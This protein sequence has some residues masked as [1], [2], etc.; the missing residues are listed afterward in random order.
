MADGASGHHALSAD[1]VNGARGRSFQASGGRGTFSATSTASATTQ[2]RLWFVAR[3]TKRDVNAIQDR[4]ARLPHRPTPFRGRRLAH[5]RRTI[6]W[7]A[8][9]R[10]T[11]G[12]R[13]SARS[14]RRAASHRRRHA[15][16][17]GR[18]AGASD[19]HPQPA[20][21]GLFGVAKHRIR[22]AMRRN[23][24]RL[25][26]D[27]QLAQDRCRRLH[28]GG[29]TAAAHDDADCRCGAHDSL[30][31]AGSA[32][33]E[34][35]SPLVSSFFFCAI[36]SG[37][38]NQSSVRSRRHGSWMSSNMDDRCASTLAADQGSVGCP[39]RQAPSPTADG[40]RNAFHF[41]HKDERCE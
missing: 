2:P 20:P 26:G 32:R 28:G 12:L 22:H 10:C 8:D 35:A 1:H 25:M 36:G 31:A 9:R 3:E 24:A 15:R 29:V 13:R 21:L 5:S 18:T 17:M 11:H 6:S 23:H 34:S 14:R 30:I 37:A 4:R 19:D 33:R 16:Q 27:L 40:W 41:R 38:G 7:L 39:M